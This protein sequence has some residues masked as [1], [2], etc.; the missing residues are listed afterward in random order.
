MIKNEKLIFVIEFILLI[1]LGISHVYSL[2]YVNLFITAIIFLLMLFTKIENL[3]VMLFIA[4]PFFNLFNT[5]IGTISFYYIYIIIF[6]IKYL[7]YKKW[8]IEG[9]KILCL[10]LLVLVRLTSSDFSSLIRWALLLSVLIL[11]Y[12]EKFF[13]R[14]IK[15]IVIL[16]SISFLI[17]SAF[18]YY[19]LEHGMSIYT[20]GYVYTKDIGSTIRFAG[21]IG[22]PV[23]Y[24]QFTALLISSCLVICYFNKEGNF[25]IYLIII[26]LIIFTIYTYSKTGIVLSILSILIYLFFSII[27]NAKSKKTCIRSIIILILSI[28][29]TYF[30]INYIANHTENI[31][32]KNYFTRF[33][34]SDILTGRNEISNHYINL[35]KDDWK[36]TI[37]P[38]SEKKYLMP[39][40]LKNGKMINRSHNIYIETICIFGL[41]AS[42]IIFVWLFIKIVNIVKQKN[43][44]ICILPMLV[45]IL[46]GFSLHG[47]YE[48]Q[49]YFLL[50]IA[51]AFLN[52]DIYDILNNNLQSNQIG[53]DCNE[54]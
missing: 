21:L 47:H 31:V 26:A 19:M 1:F 15:N 29:G 17:S 35:L 30:S 44:R 46:S 6:I 27:K 25:K 5:N 8:K 43:I 49:Y 16:F 9:H 52:K 24:S 10:L 12:N 3:I 39:F 51:L 40:A 11:T 42:V 38:M 50:A 22:D 20:G 2:T 33:T 48:F 37:I 36:T 34:T 18:G 14:Q 4:L 41:L 32:I 53:G 54:K 13:T 45:I 28:I 7:N 23:F